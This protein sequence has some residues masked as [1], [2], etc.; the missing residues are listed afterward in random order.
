VAALSACAATLR[1]VQSVD[2]EPGRMAQ[3][4]RALKS[5]KLISVD[6]DVQGVA[7]DLH[8]IDPHLRLSYEP[9][10][11]VWIVKYVYLTAGG[12]VKE[13]LVSSFQECD[14]RIVRRVREIN[15]PGYDFVAELDRLDREAE[16]RKDHEF[17]EKI[18]PHAEK[19]A[20]ALRQDLGRNER[21][22]IPADVPKG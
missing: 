1:R 16:R 17:S 10:E 5:G 21:A 18:G 8:E 4:T 7:N 22:V 11:D 15:R 9:H 20:W 19:L 6:D 3:V 12:E 13:R 2:I 14:Q